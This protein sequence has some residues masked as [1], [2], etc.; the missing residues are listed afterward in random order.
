MLLY[1]FGLAGVGMLGPDEPRY[2]AIGREMAL[3]GDW[4]TPRLW[5]E[6]WFE[7][8]AL[9]YWLVALGNLAGFSADLAPRLPVAALSAGFLVFFFLWMR[10]EFGER[11]ALYAAGILATS[12]GWL[13]YSH[14]AVTDLPLAATF[15]ASMMLALPW[16]RCG[17]RRGLFIGGLLLGLAILAKG[18]VPLVLVIPLIWVGRRRWPDLLL[19][20]AA[21][22]A[23][24]AP[25]YVLVWLENGDPFLEVFFWKHHF[26]RFV[27]DEIRHT[28]P[29]YF[30]IPV[31]LGLLFPW[32]PALVALRKVD[33]REPRRL[34]LGLWAAW[35]FLFF[36]LSANKLPGYL[37][38]LLPPIAALV[39]IQFAHKPVRYIAPICALLVIA[40]PLAAG[41]LPVAVLEGLSRASKPAINWLAV[42]VVFAAAVGIWA[43]ERY[44]STDAA[45][46]ASGAL[47]AAA[48]VGLIYTT[49]PAL[50]KGA[51]ARPLWSQ[52]S[53]RGE[54][55]C[56]DMVHRGLR[57]GVFYYAGREL[58]ACT[59]D[60]DRN[61]DILDRDSGESR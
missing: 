28:Q 32:S 54:V 16:V 11:S 4:I 39:G 33:W 55:P 29:W 48:I 41:I 17:G 3:T 26:S 5:G 57:Y 61:H 51:S 50:D 53:M 49:Y 36:S 15:S 43:V 25:W 58:P 56:V 19:M 45:M 59:G 60:R 35:G 46:S 20:G 22:A 44:R 12:A 10:R 9:L 38:P 47:M 52:M 23:V 27:S 40:L 2:A 34:L 8:P 31:L 13:V 42:A 30:Y 14:V 7:K 1:F 37:L 24:A 21:A 6:P 18:L